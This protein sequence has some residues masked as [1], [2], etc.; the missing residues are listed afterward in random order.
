[1]V[2]FGRRLLPFRARPEH[3][4][5]LSSMGDVVEPRREFIQDNLLA[6]WPK[7]RHL[8]SC[9]TFQQYLRKRHQILRK[10]PELK[11]DK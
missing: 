9:W 3:T 11:A 2:S 6:A 4:F 1:M 8:D 7:V 5:L 10:F